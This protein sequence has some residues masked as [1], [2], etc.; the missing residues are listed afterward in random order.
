MKPLELTMKAFGPYK[1]TETVDF[2]RFHAGLYLITGDTGAGKT[3]IYDAITFALFEETS[4]KPNGK[5]TEK[6]SVRDKT[7]VHSHFA[8]K[9]E[10][11]EVTLRFE[12]DGTEYTVKRTCRYSK[13][14]GT[15]DEYGDAHFDAT[16][17]DGASVSE[18]GSERVTRRIEE[19]IGM[20]AAQF[21]QI[22]MLA[23]GEFKAFM[24]ARDNTR[25]DILS[26]L[27]DSSSAVALMET[28]SAAR[29]K[30]SDRA[31]AQRRLREAA[32]SED[33]FPLPNDMPPDERALYAPDHPALLANLRSLTDAE[34]ASLAAAEASYAKADEALRR[35][36]DRLATASEHNTELQ[37]RDALLRDRQDLEAKKPE[38]DALRRTLARAACAVRAVY[39]KYADAQRAQTRTA[40]AQ[41][42]LTDAKTRLASAEAALLAAQTEAEANPPRLDRAQKAR[43]QAAALET[44]LPDYDA[45]ETE[46]ARCRDAARALAAAA[47]AKTTALEKQ[48]KLDDILR[49]IDAEL[50]TL[51]DTEAEVVRAQ[52]E[53]DAASQLVKDL[54]ALTKQITAIRKADDLCR[55]LL[56]SCQTQK[57]AAD[58]AEAEHRRL[59][60]SFLHSQAAHLAQKLRVDLRETGS[61]VCPVCG[62]SAC[63]DDAARFAPLSADTV[64]EEQVR[65]ARTASEAAKTRFDEINSTLIAQMQKRD[66]AVEA[67]CR[68]ADRLLPEKAP[69]TDRTLLDE[70][71]LSLLTVEKE[72]A[73]NAATEKLT[74]ARNNQKRRQDLNEAR[75]LHADNRKAAADRAAEQD[76]IIT[77]RQTMLDQLKK[78]CDELRQKLPYDSKAAAQSAL[79]ALRSEA[80]QLEA[81]VQQAED[82]RSSAQTDRASA[83]AFVSERAEHLAREQTALA[84]AQQTFAAALETNGFSDEAA[85]R[86]ALPAGNPS[87]YEPFLSAQS[88]TLNA[89]DNAVTNTNANLQ[90]QQEKVREYVYTDLDLLQ[91]QET[92]ETAALQALLNEKTSLESTLTQ[93]RRATEKIEASL[94]E[95][96]RIRT[97]Y[98][99]LSAL[100]ET[101][102]GSTGDGGRHAF[103]G[104][105][106]GRS[107]R[108][109][110]RRA[111][112]HLDTMTGGRYTLVHESSGRRKSSASD[113][114]I[115][116]QDMY[117][118]EQRE[119][120]SISGGES[121]QVSMALALGLSDVA[122]AHVRGGKRIDAMFIDEGFG[123]LDSAALG[124][125]LTALKNAAGGSRLVGLI[126]HVDGLEEVIADKITVRSLGEQK[127]STILQ[128]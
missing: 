24:E 81:A 103:D 25:K 124:S 125:M 70:A 87:G 98:D 100:A 32:L 49:D 116:I 54:A 73:A 127:G 95:Y 20:D 27:F 84:A 11:T 29:K 118:G 75:A 120:G 90:T 65:A 8:P 119:I 86:A 74:T 35:L 111:T 71:L 62:K 12:E 17:S 42:Q 94:R 33:A 26:K 66:S 34:A 39:P 3:T 117:T 110:L 47:A 68:E 14:R 121:F 96:D 67:A 78:R 40:A 50:Q 106:L 115:Q 45:L 6:G 102:S 99:R 18:T 7:M 53:V 9:S 57:A 19:I 41:S 108:E 44:T 52:S 107:F 101:A 126:S 21:R 89:Y 55:T 10:P 31:E 93:H 123:S 43:A 77:T 63:A 36:R 91:Q 46:S 58:A 13:K 16:L 4:N 48:T 72:A 2:T 83:E 15:A 80:A 109:I 59:N 76:T 61:A 22:V 112:L 113:F 105:V 28:L 23:Q 5:D 122:Q 60:D 104:F 69:W 30:L 128:P 56:D 37:R 88:E 114:V 1:D 38:M 79:A 85:Y 97:A 82:K 64:T 92:D 51:S